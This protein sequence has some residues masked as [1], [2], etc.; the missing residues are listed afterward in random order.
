LVQPGLETDRYRLALGAEHDLAIYQKSDDQLVTVVHIVSPFHKMA[1][2]AR[3]SYLERRRTAQ[4]GQAHIVE[5]DLISQ[6]Y[7]TI[8]YS[9]E[10]LPT[11]DYTVTVTRI[12]HPDRHE[13][14][15]ATLQK[16][17]P[18]FRLPRHVGDRDIVVDLQ[19]VFAMA[20]ER[21]GC[22]GR[23]DYQRDPPRPL[24]EEDRRWLASLLQ[25]KGLRKSHEEIAVAAY[26]LWEQ[27]GR[28][29]GR[30]QEH[31]RRALDGLRRVK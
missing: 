15:T 25:E 23:I 17:L 12:P 11:W 24:R 16:R 20:Y 6:G 31:W 28:P 8:T 9:R 19:A 13:L 2:T 10:H 14:Y 27:E 26:Y 4:E 1:G 5:I 29:H 22:G 7:P 30:D 21:S 3:E 18:R